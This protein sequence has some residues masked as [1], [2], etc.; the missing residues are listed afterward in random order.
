MSISKRC[1]ETERETTED[2]AGVTVTLSLKYKE[3]SAMPALAGKA[4]DLMAII[5]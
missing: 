3:Q 5:Y 1:F 4:E 2:V